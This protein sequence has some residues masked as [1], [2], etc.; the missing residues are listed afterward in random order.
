MLS[1]AS[2]LD[3]DAH[4]I[5]FLGQPKLCQST[6]WHS[7]VNLSRV[8]GNFLFQYQTDQSPLIHFKITNYLVF[9]HWGMWSVEATDRPPHFGFAFWFSMFNCWKGNGRKHIF[10]RAKKLAFLPQN[11]KLW[12]SRCWA[13]SLVACSRTISQSLRQTRGLNIQYTPDA[14]ATSSVQATG[15]P[16]KLRLVN[17]IYEQWGIKGTLSFSGGPTVL[18]F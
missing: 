13:S 7:F 1:L 5:F 14:M 16:E 6:Y 18:I 17:E 9:C 12:V 11:K 15:I 10:L 8:S 2:W 4:Q 3:L